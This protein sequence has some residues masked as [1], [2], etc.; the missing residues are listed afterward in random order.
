MR[1]KSIKF[2]DK[3]ERTRHVTK[4]WFEQHIESVPSKN[5]KSKA[6]WG[7]GEL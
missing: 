2:E 5:E 7:I 4:R 6:N 3:F 1:P